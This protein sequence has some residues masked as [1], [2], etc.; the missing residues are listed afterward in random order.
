MDVNS[1]ESYRKI[2]LNKPQKVIFSIPLPQDR[3]KD[4]YVT[5]AFPGMIMRIDNI[6]ES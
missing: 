1:S 2:R 5:L 4:T 6:M 3:I